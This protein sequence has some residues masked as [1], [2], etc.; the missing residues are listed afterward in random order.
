MQRQIPTKTRLFI[1]AKR[2]GDV[3]RIH[4]I[5]RHRAGVKPSGNAVRAVQVVCPDRRGE[6][7][8]MVISQLDGL[9]FIIKGIAASTGPKISS[10]HSDISSFTPSSSVG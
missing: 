3:Q 6:G 4:G 5:D 1:A 8:N 2:H 9:L 7:I 10:F